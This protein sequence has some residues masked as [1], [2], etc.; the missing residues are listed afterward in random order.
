MPTGRHVFLQ[1]PQTGVDFPSVNYSFEMKFLVAKERE[2]CSCSGEDDTGSSSSDDN[3][4][5]QFRWAC[6]ADVE[7]PYPE[8]L[9]QCRSIF[10]KN[11]EPVV[12]DEEDK[13]AAGSGGSAWT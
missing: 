2:E 10:S 5:Y 3:S 11:N 6:P 1:P 13:A 8:I 12:V 4:L 9:D 7:D